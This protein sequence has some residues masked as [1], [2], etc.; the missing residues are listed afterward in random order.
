M[1]SLRFLI[2]SMLAFFAASLTSAQETPRPN[3]VVDVQMVCNT[4]VGVFEVD[5]VAARA[6]LPMQYEL[7]LQPSGAALVYLQASECDGAGNGEQLG[8]FD[9]A[10]AWLAIAGEFVI[11]DVPGAWFTAPTIN[12]YVLKAQTTSSW[13]KTHTA[14]IYFPKEL[15]QSLDVGGAIALMRQGSVGEMTGKGYSWV[16]FVPCIGLPGSQYGE[17]WM[18]PGVEPKLPI[19]FMETP[20]ML[21]TNVLGYVDR[22]PGNGARKEMACLM[23]VG[24]QGL[25][26]L[27][28]G[29]DSNLSKLGVFQSMQIG[30]FWDSTANCH[31]I[32]SPGK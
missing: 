18:F 28:V 16:E 11:D 8:R 1:F 30:Y 5:P 26:Q 13:I 31:L 6:A 14:A 19:G 4:M 15:I 2:V 32:M 24:G 9:L 23:E 25:V 20:F 7:A 22:S 12:V 17:C 27:Q 21:G 3:D 29:P 10:D